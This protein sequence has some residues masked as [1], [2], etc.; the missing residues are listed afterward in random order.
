MSIV[1]LILAIPILVGLFFSHRAVTSRLRSYSRTAARASEIGFFVVLI[2][3]GIMV[4]APITHI[5]LL[6]VPA[7]ALYLIFL[8][9]GGRH[10]WR[11]FVAIR[12]SENRSR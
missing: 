10:I 1:A 8:V 6:T 5:Q 7:Y 11:W 2:A 3:A 9:V 4:A 12:N